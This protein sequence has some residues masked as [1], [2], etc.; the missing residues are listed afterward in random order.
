M[1]S[2]R[3]SFQQCILRRLRAC[4]AA[5]LPKRHVLTGG[6]AALAA[7]VACFRAAVPGALWQRDVRR[8][9]ARSLCCSLPSS[10]R[11]RSLSLS[12]RRGCCGGGVSRCSSLYTAASLAAWGRCARQRWARASATNLSAG[13]A[14]SFPVRPAARGRR[15]ARV[16]YARAQANRLPGSAVSGRA[17]PRAQHD[18]G[19][20]GA[21]AD[22]CLLC[23]RSALDLRRRCAA[24]SGEHQGAPWLR[25]VVRPLRFHPHA[26]HRCPVA[27]SRLPP[28][29]RR[30]Q[31]GALSP[32]AQQRDMDPHLAA[33][34][35]EAERHPRRLEQPLHAASSRSSKSASSSAAADGGPAPAAAAASAAPAAGRPRPRSC[36]RR[37]LGGRRNGRRPHPRPVAARST[38]RRAAAKPLERADADETDGLSVLAELPRPRDATRAL[39]PVKPLLAF[40]RSHPHAALMDDAASLEAQRAGASGGGGLIG[41]SA[42]SEAALQAEAASAAARAC[43]RAAPPRA[44][45]R[46]PLLGTAP[47]PLRSLRW[48]DRGDVGVHAG[49]ARECC[50]GAAL[51]ARA[52]PRRRRQR[53][54]RWP[55]RRCREPRAHARVHP[56]PPGGRQGG[57]PLG[58]TGRCE[59]MASA[60]PRGRAA[61]ARCH[62]PCRWV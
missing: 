42:I 1:R 14:S 58:F 26:A 9:G 41:G 35:D 30:A 20:G 22:R 43:L 12:R 57:H 36:R 5:T 32:G 38:G 28:A 29:R 6:G 18:G 39:P 11:W 15:V 61:P 54:E 21:G 8:S 13:C 40:S 25:L 51:A 27:Q 59:R 60:P 17:C 47:L 7:V 55:F 10:A 46:T 45:A 56:W 48:F 34:L 33:L 4:A 49:A 23:K 24:T 19:G 3:C 37:V 16:L 53:R 44:R 31:G 50:T 2:L 52:A 62:R